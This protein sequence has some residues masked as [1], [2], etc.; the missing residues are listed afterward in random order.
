MYSWQVLAEYRRMYLGFGPTFAGEKLAEQ[1]LRV[2]H[3]TL[4]RWLMAEGLWSS[5]RNWQTSSIP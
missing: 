2:S 1:G 5:Q 3:D 4:R